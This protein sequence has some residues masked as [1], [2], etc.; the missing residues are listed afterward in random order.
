VSQ[1]AR[2]QVIR[3]LSVEDLRLFLMAV[4]NYGREE[5]VD[6]LTRLFPPRKKF[7]WGLYDSGMIRETRL[8]LGRKVRN[9]V[10][11]QVTKVRTDIALYQS[12]HDTAII[13]VDCGDFHLVE[14]S[15]NFRLWTYAGRPVSML[16]DRSKRVFSSHEFIYLIPAQHA[17]EHPDG[18]DAHLAV[19][20]KGLW[21]RRPLEFLIEEYGIDLDPTK[22]LTREDYEELKYKH[23]LPV[24]GSSSRRW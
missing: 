23:R 19:T 18:S 1:R 20:H 10:V 2:D 21:Q 16:P 17:R 13:Y 11:E 7:L 4:E 5:D 9:A 15:H 6:D 22:L 24:R 14:G 3:W 8:I 12:N